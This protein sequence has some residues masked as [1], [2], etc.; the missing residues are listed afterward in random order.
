MDGEKR[1]PEIGLHATGAVLLTRN[2]KEGEKE[3]EFSKIIAKR[4]GKFLV[5]CQK[6]L[7]YYIY[8]YIYIYI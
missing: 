1:E 7:T 5:K 8:I 4:E 3:R 6:K 2:A